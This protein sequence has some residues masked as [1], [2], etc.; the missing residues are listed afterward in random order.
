VLVSGSVAAKRRK[1]RQDVL[2]VLHVQIRLIPSF[3]S[4][5]QN[6]KPRSQSV[7]PVPDLPAGIGRSDLCRH[8]A[9]KYFTILEESSFKQFLI[10]SFYILL[11]S[12]S[13]RSSS[14]QAEGQARFLKRQDSLPVS[15]ISQ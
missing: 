10:G 15:M 14:G 4:K 7:S 5:H 12:S 13:T 11:A 8:H 3:P 9:K 1:R 2:P 6:D